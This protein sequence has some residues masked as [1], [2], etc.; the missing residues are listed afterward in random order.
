MKTSFTILF[1]LLGTA[2]SQA[3]TMTAREGAAKSDGGRA[4]YGT[5]TLTVRSTG[6]DHE[7]LFLNSERDFRDP[8]NL[9]P[10]LHPHAVEELKKLHGGD[11]AAFFAGRTIWVTGDA[12]R[13]PVTL[14]KD[15]KV[16][17]TYFQ[18]RIAVTDAGQ[19]SLTPPQ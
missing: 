9:S 11:L 7:I 14:L 18:H 10:S 2:G 5:F 19:I 6:G 12:E 16:V 4:I 1:L 8:R 3:A 17:G 15:G 13:V